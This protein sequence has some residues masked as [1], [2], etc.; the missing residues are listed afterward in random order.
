MNIDT[1]IRA[2]QTIFELLKDRGYDKIPDELMTKEEIYKLIEEEKL[3]VDKLKKRFQM[4]AEKSTERILIHWISSPKLSS[5]E[6]TSLMALMKELDIHNAIVIIE[7]SVTPHVKN[8]LRLAKRKGDIIEVFT[9]EELQFN[10]SK[11]YL[12]P[13]HMICSREEKRRVKKMYGDNFPEIRPSDPQMRYLGARK[14]QLIK[15]IR[16]SIVLEGEETISYREVN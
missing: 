6:C 3:D 5:P 9:L 14:G 12:V 2:R 7:D 1:L 4:I 16:P 13:K 8:T 10:V 11:H 15:I